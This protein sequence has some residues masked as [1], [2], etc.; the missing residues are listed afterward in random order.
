MASNSHNRGHNEDNAPTDQ[1][2]P[3]Q[4]LSGPLERNPSRTSRVG[5]RFLSRRSLRRGGSLSNYEKVSEES[6]VE[7]PPV[8]RRARP[9]Q[10]GHG[11]EDEFHIEDP[12]TF[13][14]A[15]SAVG[16]SFDPTHST[17][18]SA[19][20]RESSSDLINVPLDDFGPQ[21]AEH[22]LSPTDTYEDTA[23]LTDHRFLQ[24]ISGASQ[25]FSGGQ[26][27]RGS[28]HGNRF[29]SDS[30]PESRLGDDLPHLESGL[31]RRR[32]GSSS[33]GDSRLVPCL[34]QPLGLLCSGRV[35]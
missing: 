10:A 22:Y 16:L 1:S 11:N 14:Q 3:L 21:E 15:M 27:D 19:R 17:T 24:P 8:A 6:P 2:I 33:A 13:A 4:D 30:R 35:R 5:N 18:T 26:D 31:G 23:P 25:N 7:P 32:R 29:P 20:R 28:T 12:G 9:Q 34:L